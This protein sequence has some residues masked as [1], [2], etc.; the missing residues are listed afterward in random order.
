MKKILRGWELIKEI[1][2]GNIKEGS[3]FEMQPNGT[4]WEYMNKTLIGDRYEEICSSAV[5]GC[6]FRI[7]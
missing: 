3:K 6:D 4:I 5:I 2:E 7:L 1:E